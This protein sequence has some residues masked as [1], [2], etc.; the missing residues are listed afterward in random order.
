MFLL[1]QKTPINILQKSTLKIKQL[2]I[3][4]V[5]SQLFQKVKSRSKNKWGLSEAIPVT[6]FP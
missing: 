1:V 5:I 3:Q 6:E 2:A 4:L